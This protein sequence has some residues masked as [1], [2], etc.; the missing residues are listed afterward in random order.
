MSKDIEKNINK[1]M[2]HI[3]NQIKFALIFENQSPT[4]ILKTYVQKLIKEI[5]SFQF[6]ENLLK[7]F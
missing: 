5:Q 7:I 1:K 2:K 6:Y 4:D 3:Y